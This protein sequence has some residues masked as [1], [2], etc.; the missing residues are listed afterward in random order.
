[1][2]AG[3][4]RVSPP[5]AVRPAAPS[6]DEKPLAY[7]FGPFELQPDE[8]RLLRDA[9]PVPLAS[10]AFDTLLVLVQRAGS[11]VTKDE[12]LHDVW[13]DASVEEANIAV[14]VAAIRR[15]IGHDALATVRKHGYRF[16]A[17]VERVTSTA[18]AAPVT[19]H[20]LRWRRWIG[21][22][23]LA[24][25]VA[26]T[27]LL[28]VWLAARR[29]PAQS[30]PASVVEQPDLRRVTM[31]LAPE[32]DVAWSSQGRLA[33]TSER[34]GNAEI[35]VVNTDGQQ[36]RLT[37]DPGRDQNP[38][39]SSDGRSLAFSSDRGGDGLQIYVM[40]ADGSHVRRVTRLA[41]SCTE[42]N[43]APDGSRLAFQRND[44]PEIGQ[45]IYT[46]R[47]DG[48]DLRR[49][50]AHRA[51]DVNPSWHPKGHSIAFA[52]N[53]GGRFSIFAVASTG[54][55]PRQLSFADGDSTQPS[56]SP[57][58]HQIAFVSN[59]NGGVPQLH[60][61]NDDGTASRPVQLTQ[62]GE[63]AWSPDGAQLAFIGSHDGNPDVYL[64]ALER[65]TNLTPHV[66]DDNFG[67]CGPAGRVAFSS[68]RD[69][70]R[71]IYLTGSSSREVTKLTDGTA[72]DWF[73]SWSPDGQRIVFQSDRAGTGFLDLYVM[74]LTGQTVTR[75]TGGRGMKASPAWSP[76]GGSIAFQGNIDGGPSNFQI[77]TVAPDGS[78][79]RRLTSNQN[80]DG[81]PAWSPDSSRIAFASDRHGN[82]DVFAMAR[83]GAAVVR[84]TS[85]PSRDANPS[86]SAD[87]TQIVFASDR[88]T[89]RQRLD[90][91]AMFAS[92]G[93]ATR[94]TTSGGLWPRWCRDQS[95]IVFTSQRSGND[96]VFMLRPPK[97]EPAAPAVESA[98]GTRR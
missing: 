20:S 40:N 64:L 39:W 68:N 63:P 47:V 72:N 1:M 85:G 37:A 86:W 23:A 35:Y 10:R 81:D 78:S 93:S 3:D 33:M 57:D 29:L 6:R 55:V 82:F 74:S 95:G 94:L 27:V 87:G 71:A 31:T 22:V 48:S 53:R 84:L 8:R 58:G 56:W 30:G 16:T 26:C 11:L 73:P 61:M 38:A 89:P 5:L 44:D 66:A 18:S 32:S 43:W 54:G 67:T 51:S 52:S 65:T 36:V 7:R 62:A 45:D 34:D 41:Q 92:G 9:V 90:L 69:G 28:G 91:Y 24:G 25:C 21:P 50:T 15:V 49:L 42:P 79:L 60:L 17:P 83:D 13:R 75:I 2:C 14:T 4:A 80:Y 77:Y 19:A 70:R 98:S 76:D 12:L 96:D 59:Q 88:A 97:A 46:V